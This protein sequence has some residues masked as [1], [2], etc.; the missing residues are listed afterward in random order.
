MSPWTADTE[1]VMHEDRFTEAVQAICREDPRYDIEAY[2][3]IR[4]ALDF[5]GRSLG[6]PSRGEGRHVSGEELLD[7]I[8]RYALQEY[9]PMTLTVLDSWGIRRT[10]DLGE[11][12]FNLVDRGILGSTEEDKKEDFAA[13]YDFQE[14]FVEPFLPREEPPSSSRSNQG[15]RSRRPP[16]K[17]SDR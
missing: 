17:A 10:E 7:G 12:V 9:G 15:R 14:A 16:P 2:F 8:R 5:T 3:F 4:E 13:G 11:L 6:K 1:P